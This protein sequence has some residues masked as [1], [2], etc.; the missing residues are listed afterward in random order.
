MSEQ[1]NRS[2]YAGW[3][4][5]LWMLIYFFIVI[6]TARNFTVHQLQNETLNKVGS[7]RSS[8]FSDDR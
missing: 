8:D 6:P 1:D 4:I 7:S 3:G 2:A 5:V